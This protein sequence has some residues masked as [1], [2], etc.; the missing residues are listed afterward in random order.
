MTWGEAG[1]GEGNRG[2][3][4][5]EGKKLVVVELLFFFVLGLFL[6]ERACSRLKRNPGP[7]DC[8]LPLLFFFSYFFYLFYSILSCLILASTY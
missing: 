1:N 5:R 7:C 2:R 4:G 6:P 8:S 3:E